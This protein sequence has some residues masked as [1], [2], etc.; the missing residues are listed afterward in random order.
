MN[1]DDE[2][3]RSDEIEQWL[4]RA[5]LREPTATLD[6]RIASTI[7]P[8][9]SLARVFA[10]AA[11]IAVSVGT[12]ALIHRFKVEPGQPMASRGERVSPH[13]AV[14]EKLNV[15]PV[16]ITR[17]YGGVIREGIVGVTPDGQPLER[18]RRQTVRQVLVLDPKTGRRVSIQV[19]EE[20]VYV[21]VIKP[22]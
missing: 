9:R 20:V 21:V 19:P 22:M 3:D 8:R 1:A 2:A 10:A 17:T 4:R 15:N 14:A 11:V 5:A 7:R 6:R 18:V 16:K 13:R 12:W